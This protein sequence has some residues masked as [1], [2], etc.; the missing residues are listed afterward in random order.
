MSNLGVT[1]SDL[2]TTEQ[3]QGTNSYIDMDFTHLLDFDEE[4]AKLI[5]RNPDEE[6]KNLSGIASRHAGRPVTVQLH[7]FPVDTPIYQLHEADLYNIVQITGMVILRGERKQRPRIIIYKCPSCNDLI[8]VEQTE[9]W[10]LAPEKCAC[11][12]RKG[13]TRIFE[14]TEFDDCQWLQIQELVDNT[15]ISHSP[16]KI[17]IFIKNHL[18]DTC[19]TGETVT[20]VGIP[21]VMEKTPNSLN[22][23]MTTYIDCVGLSN[24]TEELNLD[25][26]QEDIDILKKMVADPDFLKKVI[27]SYAP[28]VYGEDLVKEALIYQQ[29]E[30]IEKFISGM[31]K[32]GQFHILMAGPPGVA[33]SILGEYQ[34]KYHFKGSEATGK[35]ASGVGLTA[36]VVQEDKEWVLKAGSMV[37][38]D[39]GLL[40]ID[41]IEKMSSNDS[42]AMHPGMEA[43]RIPISKA[44]IEATPNTRCSIVAACN[45]VGGV[46]N[47]YETLTK[48]LIE[49]GRGLTIPLLNRFAL[50]FV[51]KGEDET[52]E[53]M[54]VV[55]HILKVNIDSVDI[56]PEYDMMMLKK[57]F[58]YARTLKPVFTKE[59]ETVLRD[60]YETLFNA[61]KAEGTNIMSRRQ[62]EDLIRIS[63]ASAKLNLRDTV[64]KEDAEN[65]KRVVI[66]SLR[67]A[68]IDPSTGKIDSN[69][70]TFGAPQSRQARFKETPQVVS[71]LTSR[72]IDKTRISRMEVVNY[73]VRMWKITESEAQDIINLLVKDGT[74]YCPTPTDLAVSS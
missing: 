49:K 25:I 52:S 29:C 70:Y 2:F 11:D 51:M 42:G 21:K 14:E 74:L 36:S 63:E 13:F 45:P 66:E 72:N 56:R 55:D 12:N 28:T 54:K 15:K 59:A 3:L 5:L 64:L 33:K 48:N 35:G 62:I 6:I 31:R 9:Q 44:G 73:M 10:R 34:A 30:G 69:V 32:R 37:K 50:I 18:V 16:A 61:S 19:M 38:A 4:Y 47:D 1:E 23:E 46:W 43:Q 27:A 58:A 65:A 71:T 7:N 67:Q 17:K 53:E 40:F 39:R 20:I 24:N 26:T 8:R 41:E 68:G 60:F 57:L 22:L